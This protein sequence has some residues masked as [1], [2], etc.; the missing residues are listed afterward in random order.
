MNFQQAVA[1]APEP[2]SRSFREGKQA[3]KREHRG[4]VICGNSRRFSGSID[5]EGA[6]S[7]SKAHANENLWDYGLGLV[8]S[9]HAERAIWVEVHPACT[10]E[11]EKV[12][13]KLQW[14]RKWLRE[15]A[16]ELNKIT[17][18]REGRN[19]FWVATKAGVHIQRNSPQYR[20]LRLAGLDS[21]QRTLRVS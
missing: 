4:R 2:V 10:S 3:L 17:N 6:L 18:S 15:E 21:P 9:G 13:R 7:R 5:L 1:A 19:F 11:V 8:L 12:V 16:Q 14:L 20:R